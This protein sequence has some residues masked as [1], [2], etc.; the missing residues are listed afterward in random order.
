MWTPEELKCEEHFQTTTKRRP[1]GKF[2]VKMP[3]KEEIGFFGDSLQQTRGLLRCLVFR[4]ERNPELDRNYNNFINEFINLGHMEEI[5]DNELVRPHYKCFYMPHHCV[6]K[7]SSTTTKLRVIFDA[8]AKTTSGISLNGKLM[9]R[10][11]VQKDLFSILFRFRMHQA[12]VLVDIAKFNRQVELEEEYRV[13]HRILWKHQN[14]TEV[15]HYRM[16]RVTY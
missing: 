1:A 6:L 13:Y 2:V 12:E 4:L 9:V 5:P 14:S 7:D 16:T 15:R 11:T 3:F 10:L 8:S